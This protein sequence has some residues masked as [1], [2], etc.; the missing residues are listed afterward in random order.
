MNKILF[1]CN[2]ASFFVSHRLKVATE[3]SKIF[4][5]KL[6]LG[7]AATDQENNAL[8][9]LKK[10][11]ISFKK[12]YFKTSSL[13]L[14]TEL[15]GFFHLFLYVLIYR[16]SC[17][18]LISPKAILYGGVISRLLN[19]HSIVISISGMGS[20]MNSEFIYLRKI[21]FFF[22]NYILSSPNKKIIF[23]NKADLEFFKNKFKLKTSECILTFGS[24]VDFNKVKTIKNSF[25][26]NKLITFPA[27]ALIDKGIIE[28]IKCAENLKK[29]YPDWTFQIVGSLD[30]LSPMLLN[31]NI[32]YK[33]YKN[34]II[35]ILGYKKNILNVIKK[36][37]IICLP[38]YRE[39]MPK[40]LLEASLLG[41]PIVT[42]NIPGCREIVKLFRNGILVQK[43]NINSLQIGLEKLITNK[44]LL[45]KLKK[46]INF[47]NFE[48]VSEDYVVKKNIN[49]YLE[50]QKNYFKPI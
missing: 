11:K 49:C 6:C 23:H 5:V 37:S 46:K 30:Y 20:I 34:N 25:K 3:A 9:I 47:L 50:L 26:E 21:Y 32:I 2:H 31:K 40:V 27:R 18:H 29:K 1:I 12:F 24:G 43:K 14:L 28:F 36:S 19:V 41:K 22:L 17:T 45:K 33:Y 7:Q 38:S 8:K 15:I 44:I 4:K 16:P 35:K 42:S 13:N 10:K 48:K 39:G